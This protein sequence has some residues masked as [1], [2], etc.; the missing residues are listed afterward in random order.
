MTTLRRRLIAIPHPREG[1]WL[2]LIVALLACLPVLVAHYP[3]M[4]DYPA[5]LARYHVMLDSGR[6]ADLARYYAFVWQWTGN[7]GVD[8]LIRPFAALFGLEAGGRVIAG[9]IPVFTGLGILSVEWALRR[10]ITGASLLAFAFIWSPMML[11]GLLNFTLGLALALFAFALWV[12][13]EKWN[14]R[15]LVFLPIGLVVWLSHLSA[16]GMLGVMVFGYE[17]HRR[18][19][20]RAMIAP[21]PLLMPLFPLVFGHGTSGAFSYGAYWWLYK[22][23]IW[24]KA[25]RDQLYGLDYFSLIAV[26][27]TVVLALIFRRFDGRLGR[28]AWLLLLGSLV[29]PRHIS[30]GDY[31]DYRMISSGLM[32]AVLAIDWP[33][34]RLAL[35]LS[36]L[37]FA[38][39]LGVTTLA[40]Q[41]DSAETERLL[42][43]LDHVPQGAR[44]ASAVQVALYDWPL[45][46]FEH[47][48]GYAVVRRDALVNANFALAHVHMLSLKTGGP[49][50]IDPSQR[51]LQS[52]PA[53]VDLNTFAPAQQAD[54]LWYVGSKDQLTL[55]LGA[56][57][58]YATPHSVL[59]HLA[60]RAL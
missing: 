24:I 10:R 13:L 8:I 25:M 59:L 32:L 21:W 51:I 34:T 36:P 31:A 30:G 54:Y 11:I 7:L 18:G 44:L 19:L 52:Q 17:W 58:L 16:W 15:W 28:A 39:R 41:A 56:V 26:G 46:H 33:A 50:F 47:I 23:G 38:A 22:Q 14:Y 37:L 57:P 3:Q 43:G 1:L 42:V 4:S 27:F 2:G 53:P 35:W 29:M 40:W 12:R 6:S 49:G 20:F 9:L 45:N 5:H 48:G 55:P 60:K